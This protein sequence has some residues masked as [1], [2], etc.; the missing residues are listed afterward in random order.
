MPKRPLPNLAMWA[1]EDAYS[2]LLLIE[3]ELNAL[4]DDPQPTRA[5]LVGG[6]ARCR[7]TA[8]NARATITEAHPKVRSKVRQ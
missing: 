7:V 8:A 4:M 3:R 1:L 2:A 6:M 5:A